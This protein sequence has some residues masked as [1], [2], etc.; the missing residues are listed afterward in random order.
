MLCQITLSKPKLESWIYKRKTSQSHFETKE[1]S[2]YNP[3]MNRNEL[4]LVQMSLSHV[5]KVNLVHYLN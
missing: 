1:S 4:R 5:G 2:T 3:S